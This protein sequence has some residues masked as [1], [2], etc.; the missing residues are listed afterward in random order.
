MARANRDPDVTLIPNPWVYEAS[1]YRGK[2]IR[3]T[4]DWDQNDGDL[5]TATVFRDPECVYTKIFIGLGDDGEP[6]KSV[7]NWVIP[8]GT[9]VVPGSLLK[10]ARLRNINDIAYSQITA[11]N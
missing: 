6:N 5:I 9:N 1:D 3:I 2:V 7:D 8:A 4:V 11:G 10:K